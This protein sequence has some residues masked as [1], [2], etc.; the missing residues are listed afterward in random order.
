MQEQEF[1]EAVEPLWISVED[2]RKLKKYCKMLKYTKVEY[3]CSTC[4][5]VMKIKHKFC[6]RECMYKMKKKAVLLSI[7]NG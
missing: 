5:K 3:K 4:S 1:I 2:Q 7:Y 6:S